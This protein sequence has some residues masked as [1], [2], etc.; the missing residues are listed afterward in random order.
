MSYV[1]YLRV[2]R[3]GR[4]YLCWVG[5]AFVV[6]G[7]VRCK[8]SSSAAAAAHRADWLAVAALGAWS[9]GVSD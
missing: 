2:V 4:T 8:W 9:E 5:A 7:E 6:V 3:H 1:V